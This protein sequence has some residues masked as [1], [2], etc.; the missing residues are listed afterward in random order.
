MKEKYNI[1]ITR[2]VR[3]KRQKPNQ[4]YYYKN[5]GF[6]KSSF[7]NAYVLDDKPT[8]EKTTGKYISAFVP[9]STRGVF[10]KHTI[11]LSRGKFPYDEFILEVDNTLIKIIE[12]DEKLGLV[13]LKSLLIKGS[14]EYLRNKS[15]V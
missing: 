4:R 10:K 2:R 5:L 14:N 15:Q 7:D 9:T 8:L 6:T 3:D 11:H 1:Y 12:N 13:T